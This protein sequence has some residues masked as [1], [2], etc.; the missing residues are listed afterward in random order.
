MMFTAIVQHTPFWVWIVFVTLIVLGVRQSF[1]RRLRLGRVTTLPIVFVALSLAGVV[2]AFRAD[3]GALLAWA[4]GIF[5]AAGLALQ[6]GAPDAARWL[7]A[8][9]VFEVPGSWVP[10]AIMLGIFGMRFAV[11]VLLALHPGLRGDAGF[12]AL[13][14]LGYGGFSGL[15]L[16]RAMALWQLARAPRA[17]ALRDA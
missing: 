7:S 16:G 4:V 6:A 14:G 11:A 1:D 5:A 2:S 12:A 9:R 10:L 13:A 8:E 15:F 17:G 3:G